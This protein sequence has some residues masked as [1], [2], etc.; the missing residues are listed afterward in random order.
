[1]IGNHSNH[2]AFA[3]ATAR[4]VNTHKY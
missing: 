3:N 1:V 2:E 4:Q